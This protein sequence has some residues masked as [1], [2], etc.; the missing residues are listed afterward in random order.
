MLVLSK[1]S[2]FFPIQNNLQILDYTLKYPPWIKIN[3][4]AKIC[5]NTLRQITNTKG[6]VESPSP[7]K[8]AEFV[9]F[10]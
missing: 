10:L 9:L 7:L 8:K 1:T 4:M 5:E 3:L 2:G 6:T